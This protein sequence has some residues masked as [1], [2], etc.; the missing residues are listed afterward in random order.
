MGSVRKPRAGWTTFDGIVRARAAQAPDR[1]AFDFLA[2]GE[3]VDGSLT[4]GELDQRARA[5]AARLQREGEPGDR[6]LLLFP[7]GLDFIVAF[8]GC[9]YAGRIAVPAYPPRP[10][11]PSAALRSILEDAQPRWMLEAG[12]A[13]TRAAQTQEELASCVRLAVDEIPL[14]DADDWEEPT[15]E[16]SRVAMVQYTSGS[17]GRPRGVVVQH[18]HILH[19]QEQIQRAFG[20]SESSV[21]VSWLPLYH[22]MGLLGAVLQPL[23]CGGRCIL[24][25]PAAFIQRPRRWLEAISR[26]RGT[27][28]GGPD[29]GYSLCVRRIPEE[30]REGLDLSCW[31]T[32]FNGAEPVRAATLDAFAQ[33]FGS[34]GFDPAAF[35][36]CYGLAEATLFVTGGEPGAGSSAHAFDAAAFDR[37]RALSTTNPG[38]RTLISC[39]RPWGGQE[40]VIAD[41]ESGRRL[42][43]GA[44]GEIWIRGGSVAAGY[45]GRPEESQRTFGA[46][47]AGEEGD[48]GFLRTGDLGFFDARGELF[49]TGRLKDLLVIRGRNLYPQDLELIAVEAAQ[50]FGAA[51]EA[52]AAFTVEEGGEERLVVVLEMP[53]TWKGNSAELAAAVR[54]ALA[55]ELEV[56]TETVA[57][58][59]IG[60]IP[61]T[62]SGKIRRSTCRDQLAAGE[63]PVLHADLLAEARDSE[64]IDDRRVS[65]IA[66]ERRVVP[67]PGEDRL[68]WLSAAAKAVM[69]RSLNPHRPLVE[70][71][72]DSLAATEL[73]YRLESELGVAI[74]GTDL[75]EGISLAELASLEPASLESTAAASGEGQVPG[76]PVTPG[77]YPLSDGQMGL[78]IEHRRAPQSAALHIAAAAELA[79][80][81]DP[82]RLRQ[83]ATALVERHAAL[84]TRFPAVEGMPVQE[85]LEQPVLDWEE[86]AA[87]DWDHQRLTAILEEES[88][89][90]F[91]P[92]SAPPLRFRLL[93]RGAAP[94][95]LLLVMHHLVADLTSFVVLVEELGALCGGIVEG[96]PQPVLTDPVAAGCWR[97]QRLQGS[98]GESARRW[99]DEIL[100]PLPED[101]DLIPDHPRGSR[102]LGRGASLQVSDPSLRSSLEELAAHHRV[103]PFAVLMAGVRSLLLRHGGSGDLALATPVAGRSH[104]RLARMIGY[105][106]GRLVVR[107]PVAMERTFAEVLEEEGRAILGSLAHGEVPFSKL[108]AEKLEDRD[109]SRPPLA[110]VSVAWQSE[111]PERGLAAFA[112]GIAGV[113]VEVG[114][115]RM[116]SVD[117]PRRACQVELELTAVP[118]PGGDLVLDLLWDRDLWE[119][120]TAARLLDHLVRLLKAAADDPQRPLAE[121]ALLSAAERRQLK[122]WNST[123]SGSVDGLLVPERILAAA[124]EHPQRPAL[125]A[126]DG[127][128]GSTEISYGEAV[129]RALALAARLE[130]LDAG[131]ESVVAVLARRSPE[132]VI[133]LLAAHFAGAA[134]LPLSADDPPQRWRLVLDTARPCAIVA[135]EDLRGQ[136]SDLGISALSL[137]FEPAGASSSQQLVPQRLPLRPEHPAYVIL[138]SGTTGRPKGVVVSHGALLNRLVWMQE[139][140]TLDAGE[141]VLHKTPYTFDVSVWELFWPLMVGATMVVARPGGHRDPAYLAE[142]IGELGVSTVHFVP[143]LFTHFLGLGNLQQLTSLRQVVTSGE[144]LSREQVARFLELRP[145]GSRLVNL[146]GPTEAAIDVSWW[147][148]GPADAAAAVPIGHPIDGLRLHVLDSSYRPVPVGV[149]GE[150]YLSGAGLA[151]GYLGDPRRTAETF[152]PEPDGSEPGSRAYRTRDRAR[153]RPDGALEFLGRVDRQVK[154][155]GVRIEP[156]EV[157]VALETHPAVERAAVVADA[158]RLVAFVEIAAEVAGENA[159]TVEKPTSKARSADLSADLSAGLAAGLADDLAGGLA[160]YLAGQLPAAYLPSLYVPVDEMPLTRSGKLDRRALPTVEV[161]AGGSGGAPEG[162]FEEVLAAIWRR[163]LGVET[164]GREDNFFSLGGDSIRA[165]QVQEG[166]RRAGLELDLVDLFGHR[167]LSRMAAV[168]RPH[169]LDPSDSPASLQSPPFALLRAE[170][171]SVLKREPHLEDAYPLSRVFAGL[172]FHCEHSEDYEVYVTSV[173]V[174]GRFDRGAMERALEAL[175][176]RHPIFRTSFDLGGFRRPLQKVHRR[177]EPVLEVVEASDWSQ[178][179]SAMEA[180]LQAESRRPFDWSQAP[181]LRVTVHRFD[182]YGF[183]GERFRLTVAEPLLDG[184]SVAR[185]L[186]ELLEDQAA[187]AAGRSTS[188]EALRTT[189]R[190][191]LELELDALASEESQEFW[192]RVLDDAPRGRLPAASGEAGERRLFFEVDAMVSA[193]LVRAA[194]ELG[195]PLKS[196]LLAVHVAVMGRLTGE[197]DVLTGMLL[198]GRPEGP[199]AERTLGLFLNPVGLRLRLGNR[200]WAQLAQ[201]A[202]D[203]ERELLPHRR[204]PMAEL[205]RS[206]G[207]E[208][209]FDGLFN[210]THFHVYRE[211]EEIPG[212]E[213]LRGDAS[214]QTYYPVT[215][216]VHQDYGTGRLLLALDIRGPQHGG[217]DAAL[218]REIGESYLEAFTAAAANPRAP[219]HARAQLLAADFERERRWN[220]TQTRWRGQ[221]ES[222]HGL[223]AERAA[224]EGEREAVRCGDRALSYRQ[225]MARSEQLATALVAAGVQPDQ[226]VAVCVERSPE[227]LVA[228][229]GVLWAGGAFVPLDPEHPGGRLEWIVQDSLEG[230]SRPVVVAD[231]ALLRRSPALAEAL[232]GSDVVAVEEGEADA[233]LSSLGSVPPVHV[234]QLAYVL[235]TSGSTGRPKGA[236][237]SHRAIVNR[238]LWMQ[239]TFGL[240]RGEAVLHKTSIGFDV[241][242]WEL[243]WPLVA[244]A[245]V[246]MAPPGPA[247]T[248]QAV[249]ELVRSAGISTLHF[250]P[251]LLASFLETSEV[252]AAGASLRRVVVSGEALPA[253]VVARFFERFP[254]SPRSRNVLGTEPGP[255]PGLHNLYGPTEAAI[256]VTHHPCVPEDVAAA[257]PLG[258]PVS[259]TL[260]RILDRHL[261]A[262]PAGVSGELALGGV[263]LARAYLGKPALT[264]AT[265]VPDPLAQSPGQRLY[266][267]GDR[268]RRRRRDGVI[269]FEGRLDHQIKL[270]GQRIEPGEI[271]AALRDQPGVVD[272]VAG[273]REIKG[274]LRLVAWLVVS[275]GEPDLGQIRR[276]LAL[277]LPHFMVP[278]ELVPLQE[279]PRTASGKIDRR[280]LPSPASEVS[281]ERLEALLA[282]VRDLPEQEVRARLDTLKGDSSS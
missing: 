18:R 59:R 105:L 165:L 53:R 146:Y 15:A 64:L 255:G 144:A 241:S 148:C 121:L 155:R 60:G 237:I 91:D 257:I 129:H 198:N 123:G 110:Q 81:V 38:A 177:V 116:T 197:D 61:R 202:M 94:D 157:E 138:T 86:L 72:L 93:R 57:L 98:Q 179:E 212:L 40:V 128:G 236:G 133:A 234:D 262:A 66:R 152:L 214:D 156:G 88:Q 16:A 106:A 76:A 229:L 30:E 252:S 222:L 41:A 14:T 204:F 172:V 89:R 20:Q 181:L 112:L 73:A 131:P 190:H 256:D 271:E 28:S 240:E 201:A 194:Q 206:Q 58:V 48:G 266:R 70:Q 122:T 69:G 219:H 203:A 124:R 184:W 96:A 46:R 242:L 153:R 43:S 232:K 205:L 6:A 185:L 107:N 17:T 228:L 85:I 210:F 42:E 191:H 259:N 67:G 247:P 150:L 189:P 55:V 44:V 208:L 74:Q 22:D 186:R 220:A 178:D 268:A 258:G 102:F 5:V 26:Y 120:A 200:S 68:S 254:R 8:L 231:S 50:A 171:W 136:L 159:P 162:E 114:G 7:P 246:V 9:L 226:P 225:L 65:V 108:V 137:P 281:E 274:Q 163:V 261:R 71:G 280:A 170:E 23:Y 173:V 188:R 84:R 12:G 230:L 151:R 87:E 187:E 183:E 82:H 251:S 164:V 54:G 244:G 149:P 117:L 263:Q 270:R 111:N 32:A 113:E 182:E 267:T 168:A 217:P 80:G 154:V 158:G 275:D 34:R 19:N 49:V 160:D 132:R 37:N 24:L 141:R 115:L 166:A 63:L 135:E 21:V 125:L 216:Q 224:L 196:L 248:P 2:R 51:V 78:W 130:E 101:L 143:S 140:L 260:L 250:V 83:A 209:L 174:K 273:L 47:L 77:Q 126:A 147:L 238:L 207:G 4:Y 233:R 211:L 39:G 90:P 109:P 3:E 167:T 139:A 25:P 272:A 33:D 11:R 161:P 35:Y 52:S 199:D 265:F 227:L 193:A 75:L 97:Q 245:R 279:L 119:P 239:Q 118:L 264:A 10:R 1:P 36:P 29:F 79:D 103:T 92:E 277:R 221:G 104:H 45:W 175:V 276:Q 282:M 249:A 100:D 223:L 243:F 218:A 142:V 62:S 192:Q 176:A 31:R 13:G 99:W 253:D 180:W 213:V 278:S 134:Y 145:A 235:Y 269:E 95:V 169:T 215:A 195:L 27:T 127:K 56:T